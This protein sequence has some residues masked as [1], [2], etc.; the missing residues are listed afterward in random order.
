MKKTGRK[1][2]TKDSSPSRSRVE[3]SRSHAPE[4]QKKSKVPA[5]KAPEARTRRTA[6]PDDSVRDRP[7]DRVRPDAE[8]RGILA[9]QRRLAKDLT[10]FR[11]LMDLSNDALFV[12]DPRSGRFLDVNVNACKSLGYTRRELLAL[13]VPDISTRLHGATESGR[14]SSQK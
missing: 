9:E 13:R 6:D 4:S 5:S 14:R 12:V 10:L 7:S 1:K 2:Q 11:K 3:K 8:L